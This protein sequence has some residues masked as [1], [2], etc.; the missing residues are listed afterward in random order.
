MGWFVSIAAAFLVIGINAP[1]FN[2]AARENVTTDQQLQT[3]ALQFLATSE[4]L[5][6]VQIFSVNIRAQRGGEQRASLQILPGLE[7]RLGTGAGTAPLEMGAA[8]YK[9][10]DSRSWFV[11]R[12]LQALNA[13]PEHP[14]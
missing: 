11:T 13:P 6:G 10:Q 5:L 9:E 3:S 1:I 14:W 7:K 12:G 4:S 2:C 8:C